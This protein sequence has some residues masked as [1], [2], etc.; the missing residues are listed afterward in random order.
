MEGMTL[1]NDDPFRSLM[2]WD[3]DQPQLKKDHENDD[4]SS[5][6]ENYCLGFCHRCDGRYR[7]SA[8]GTKGLPLYTHVVGQKV[9]LSKPE[10]TVKKQ[11]K[12]QRGDKI[13]QTTVPKDFRIALVDHKM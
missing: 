8:C 4:K 9:C 7:N 13:N 11:T 10:F 5:D 6:D 12:N 3:A 1:D 2:A